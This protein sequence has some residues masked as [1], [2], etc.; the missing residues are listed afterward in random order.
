M[1]V[2]NIPELLYHTTL[3]V[4]DYHEDASGARRSMYVLGTHCTIEAAKAFSTSAL[5]SLG[6]E[7]DD[8]TEY[9]TRSNEPW[10]YSCIG[11]V[12]VFAR[13]PAGQ[14]FLIGID[15]TPNNESLVGDPNG[16]VVLPQKTDLLHYVLQT[17]IDYNLD[18]TGSVQATDIEGTYVHRADALK[19]AISCI[20]RDQFIEYDVRDSEEMVGQWPFGEDVIVHAVT[21]TGQNYTVAV[22]TVP[23]AHKR[24][25]KKI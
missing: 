15:T 9:A 5:Q 7:R 25:S 17:T 22:R 13:A 14:V 21:E 20:D 6:Y 2:N 10:K 11:G 12:L 23:G 24:H 4:I 8:F 3:T 19:A 18:R 1:T 16:G